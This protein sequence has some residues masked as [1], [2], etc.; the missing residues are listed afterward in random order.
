LGDLT[1]LEIATD[2]NPEKPTGVG[3]RKTLAPGM[4]RSSSEI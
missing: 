1:A 4:L 2:R 3:T